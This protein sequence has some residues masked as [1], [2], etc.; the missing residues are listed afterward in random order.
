MGR[1]LAADLV[2]EVS[3]HDIR[4]LRRAP[5]PLSPADRQAQQA[6][7]ARWALRL[8]TWKADCWA[9][10]ADC[11]WTRDEARPQE[12]IKPFPV[13]VCLDCRRYVGQAEARTD[14]AWPGPPAP[15]RVAGRCGREPTHRLE[16]IAYLPF[17]ARQ[18]QA[19]PNPD[20]VLA[21][22]KP[23][24]MLLS[25]L[26]AATHTWLPLFH[27]YVNAFLISTKEEKSG[28]LVNRCAHILAMLPE[29]AGW[30]A[31]LVPR[32]TP[33]HFVPGTRHPLVVSFPD[34]GSAIRGVAE[35]PD[36]LRQYTATAI[37]A[38]EVGTW[39]WPRATYTAMQPCIQG[40]GKIALVSSAYPGFW[41]SVVSGEL[42]Q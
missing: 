31:S 13:A 25:W 27:P 19:A 34:T 38:D 29:R 16:P 18:W 40:G 20:P 22:P 21:I 36:Q 17:L 10:I 15:L 14:L 1:A 12:P 41:R 2:A 8:V 7:A 9:W 42:T 11:V 26:M 24:R 23:R 35:G 33:G 4:P 3:V 28:E 6:E 39:K 37:L 32:W 5:A 30:P